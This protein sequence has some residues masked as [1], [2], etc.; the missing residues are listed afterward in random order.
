[1]LLVCILLLLVCHSYVTR[2]R[3]QLRSLDPIPTLLVVE[4]MDEL[5]PVITLIINLSLQSGLFPEAWKEAIVTPLFKNLTRL[6]L[7]IY[8]L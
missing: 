4:R 6:I 3:V 2:T 7:R 1:M 5:L 8:V